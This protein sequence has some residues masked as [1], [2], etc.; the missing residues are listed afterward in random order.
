[1]ESDFTF[2]FWESQNKRKEK[3]W[4][5]KGIISSSPP[6]SSWGARGR[7]CSR[8]TRAAGSRTRRTGRRW[9]AGTGRRRSPHSSGA[10]W[11]KIICLLSGLSENKMFAAW[12]EWKYNVCWAG[13]VKIKCLLSWTSGPGW[14]NIRLVS[15]IVMKIM[16]NISCASFLK[17]CLVRKAL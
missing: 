2:L 6:G 11:V 7:P 17:H 16:T 10:G 5:E 3:D 9:R 15:L 14:V 4:G 13:W 12:A 8:W 1:M